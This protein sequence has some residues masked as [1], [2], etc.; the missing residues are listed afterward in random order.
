MNG[1]NDADRDAYDENPDET[2]L[3]PEQ[4][5]A[6][7]TAPS[8]DVP[9]ETPDAQAPYVGNPYAEAYRNERY[10]TAPDHDLAV[11]AAG[12]DAPDEE[13]RKDSGFHPVH[14][15]HL[16]MGIAFLAFAGIWAALAS[17]LVESDDLRWLL[18]VPWLLAGSVGLV[19]SVAGRRARLERQR[20]LRSY[21]G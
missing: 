16:V 14:V 2:G 7:E 12:V 13:R 21:G 11:A 15:A 5:A 9:Y 10:G 20:Q 6:E 19:A 3:L 17:D 1:Q 8:T 18:P 4:E